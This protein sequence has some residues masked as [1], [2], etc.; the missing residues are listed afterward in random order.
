MPP[1]NVTATPSTISIFLSLLP[2]LNTSQNGPIT[3]YV[4]QLNGTP[5]DL[6]SLFVQNVIPVYL[7]TELVMFEITGLEEYN[8]YTF[9]VA[10]NNSVVG[11]FTTDIFVRTLQAGN[12]SHL[13][14]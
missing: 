1:R 10:A 12:I 13:R 5:F 6:P 7:A 14:L 3:N 2:P 9:S 8:D 11:A 4:V